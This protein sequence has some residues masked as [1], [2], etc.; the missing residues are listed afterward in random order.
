MS[1]NDKKWTKTD[2]FIIGILFALLV[3]WGP[4]YSMVIAPRM[5]QP[6]PV[7]AP[8]TASVPVEPAT[9]AVV[10]LSGAPAEIRPI[11]PGVAVSEEPL[12]VTLDPVKADP[13]LAGARVDP[14]NLVVISNSLIRLGVS[15]L[16]G[17]LAFAELLAYVE[18]PKNPRTLILD[19][20]AEPALS[21][22]KPNPLAPGAAELD[23]FTADKSFEVQASADGRS[24]TI[25]AVAPGGLRLERTLTLGDGYQV[26]VEDRFINDGTAIRTLPEYGVQ[27][28][29]M[30][31]PPPPKGSSS[32]G[33]SLLGIDTLS[34][35]GGEDVRL[36][37]SGSFFSRQETLPDF[38]LPLDHRGGGCSMSKPALAQPLPASIRH[39]VQDR[40]DWMAVK[41]KFFTQ[42][43]LPEGGSA[44]FTLSAMRL[45]PPQEK[46]G[47][48][49][50]WM[51]TPV[52]T[53]VSAVMTLDPVSVDPGEVVSR[54]LSYYVGPK[55]YSR[56]EPLGNR[57][58]E[59]MEFGQLR[60]ICWLLLVCLKGIYWVLPNYGL[61]I[62]LLTVLIRLIF[63]P[64]THK[65]TES[66]RKMQEIQPKIA[67]LREKYK[68]KPQKIQ[69]ETM[70]LY[71]EHKVN[72]IG[73]CLP[74]LIQIPVF[75]A[76]FNVLRSAVELRYAGFL[77]IPDLSEPEG[78]FADVLPIA[79]NILPIIMTATS[80]WQTYLT[81]SGGD[82]AQQK[83]MLLMPIMMLFIFYTMP[84]ALVLYWTANTVLMIVQLLWQKRTKK[85][86][87]ERR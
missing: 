36:W 30:F 17:G 46:P 7:K 81:P 43:L 21:L 26:A 6:P 66:M 65:S 79:L 40:T 83:M 69:E 62:I 51:T 52:L 10:T 68:D 8:V 58:V 87:D 19:F 45:V 49:S 78:L 82:P 39:P 38:F 34:T 9:N 22:V 31:Y 3:G 53:G 86:A 28:G 16:G 27:A 25:R 14:A 77:W 64:V 48:P 2:F 41:N 85:L 80:V 70:K 54:K 4:L 61:A 73:G 18:S 57:I 67:I 60:S 44:G 37:G 47:L 11:P 1:R 59:I 24:A 42:I 55:E 75:I 15:R 20:A 12:A 13:V 29:A 56:I 84:A 33:A 32:Q 63:W 50:S 76:L 35:A 71:K 23:A 72:P 74:M 5:P